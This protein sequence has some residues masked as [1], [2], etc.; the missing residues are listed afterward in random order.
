MKKGLKHLTM[1]EQAQCVAAYRITPGSRLSTKRM[2]SELMYA[3][4][5]A[6]S[7]ARC[8]GCTPTRRTA[9]WS[10]PSYATST[11]GPFTTLDE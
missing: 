3:S 11:T 9:G 5:S 8:Y 4:H 1:G 7:A 10:I 6:E 2:Y